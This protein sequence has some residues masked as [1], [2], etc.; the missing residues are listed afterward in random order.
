MI[1]TIRPWPDRSRWGTQSASEP[2]CRDEQQLDRLL[3]RLLVDGE[4][5]RSRRAA[6]VVD[7]DVDAAECLDRSL[8]EPLEVAGDRDVA[9][10]GESAQPIGLALEH[11]A[12]PREHRDVRAFLGQGFGDA[13]PDAG[14]RAADDRRPPF[15]PEIHGSGE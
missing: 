6:G 4:R 13:E 10:D 3:D 8:H 14:G 1:V 5:R 15:E 11:V 12:P 7:D 2:D 9:A